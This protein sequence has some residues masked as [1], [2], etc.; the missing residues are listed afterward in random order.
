MGSGRERSDS[1]DRFSIGART[2]AIVRSA[3]PLSA[4]AKPSVAKTSDPPKTR[5]GAPARNPD[6]R[7]RLLHRPRLQDDAARGVELTLQAARVAVEKGTQHLH[8]RS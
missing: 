2:S 6:R 7:S 3:P 8:A 1:A 5:R 4:E